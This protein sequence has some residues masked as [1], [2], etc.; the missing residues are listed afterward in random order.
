VGRIFQ[1]FT[2]RSVTLKNRIVMA[3]ML[4]YTGQEDGKVNDL[5]VAHYGARSLGGI[6]LI[7]TE[8]VAVEPRGRISHNDLGLWSR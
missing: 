4:M 3:P 1:P 2:L 6:G 7:T 5:H 8:V